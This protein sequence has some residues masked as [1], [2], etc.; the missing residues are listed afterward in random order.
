MAEPAPAPAAPSAPP[1]DA[2]AEPQHQETQPQEQPAAATPSTPDAAPTPT[3]APAPASSP[4]PAAAPAPAPHAPPVVKKFT[5]MNATRKFLEKTSASTANTIP[6]SGAAAQ[7]AAASKTPA[8]RPTVTPSPSASKLVAA[9]LSTLNSSSAPAGWARPPAPPAATTP[10]DSPTPAAAQPLQQL[11]RPASGSKTR[12]SSPGKPVWGS[13]AAPARAPAA[14]PPTSDFPTAAEAATRAQRERA[15]PRAGAPAANA[16][17][18]PSAEQIRS[19]AQKQ[20]MAETAAVFRGAHLDPNASHWDEMDDDEGF[21]DAVVEFGDGTQYKVEA[22]VEHSPPRPG[23]DQ[24][25]RAG[26]HANGAPPGQQDDERGW[27]RVTAKGGA[28][29]SSTSSA[30]TASLATPSPLVSPHEPPS[31]ALY[32]DRSGRFEPYNGKPSGARGGPFRRD[33]R[34]SAHEP[35]PHLAQRSPIQLLQK[36][37]PGEHRT[38]PQEAARPGVGPAR[39]SGSV[40]TLPSVFDRPHERGRPGA[41]EGGPPSRPGSGFHAQSQRGSMGPPPPPSQLGREAPPHLGRGPPSTISNGRESPIS[42]TSS[43]FS[44]RDSVSSAVPPAPLSIGKMASPEVPA[45]PVAAPAVPVPT[46][47]EQEELMKQYRLELAEKARKRRQEEEE[48]RNREKE[49]ARKKAA[50][51]EERMEAEKRAKEEA[52]AAKAEAE[53]KERERQEAERKEAAAK[54]EAERQAEAERKAAAAAAARAAAPPFERP[55]LDTAASSSRPL[56]F[57]RP[58]APSERGFGFQPAPPVRAP[59]IK[60]PPTPDPVMQLDSWRSKAAPPPSPR[61]TTPV[62]KPTQSFV[63]SLFTTDF[64]LKPDEEVE[65]IDFSDISKLAPEPSPSAPVPPPAPKPPPQIQLLQRPPGTF[66]KPGAPPPPGPPLKSDTN[67]WRKP[68]A[69]TA[70]TSA[71]SPPAAPPASGG[72]APWARRPADGDAQAKPSLSP[73]ASTSPT[74]SPPRKHGRTTSGSEPLSPRSVPYREAP[75]SALTDTMSRI[76]GAL[77]GMQTEKE[78]SPPS[79]RPTEAPPAQAK[80]KPNTTGSVW[81]EREANATAKRIASQGVSGDTNERLMQLSLVFLPE[82]G[83]PT[84]RVRLPAAEAEPREAVSKKQL[85]LWQTITHVRFD[86]LSLDPPPKGMS[87]RTLMV[88]ESLFDRLHNRKGAPQYTV[89]LPK[90]RL[91]NSRALARIEAAPIASTSSA[92]APRLPHVPAPVRQGSN[93]APQP[94][95]GSLF[96]TRSKGVDEPSWRKPAAPKPEQEPQSEL[97]P[98]SRSPPPDMDRPSVAQP[99]SSSVANPDAPKTPPTTLTTPWGQSPLGL[100]TINSPSS[101]PPDRDH[102]KQVWSQKLDKDGKPSGNSLRD[103][104][105]EPTRLSFS[106]QEMK[107][108]EGDT[109]P[110]TMS[111]TNS[112]TTSVTRMSV[113]DAHRAFQ[114]VPSSSSA[115]SSPRPPPRQPSQNQQQPSAPTSQPLPTHP[116]ASPHRP[117]QPMPMRIFGPYPPQGS[118]HLAPAP[119][120]SHLYALPPQP[121]PGQQQRP[122]VN[123]APPQMAQGWVVAPAGQQP[124][125]QQFMRP[126]PPGSPYMV[127]YGPP[128]PGVYLTAPP[129]GQPPHQMPKP[130]QP[131]QPGPP[132]AGRG[133]GMPMMSPGPSQAQPH[134]SPVP[135]P[136]QI[137]QHMAM[138]PYQ[139]G[140]I[141]SIYHM[142]PAPGQGMVHPHPGAPPGQPMPGMYPGGPPR[143]PIMQYPSAGGFVPAPPPQQHAPFLPRPNW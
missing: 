100:S 134:I 33:S 35:P 43:R 9:K 53:R 112:G 56:S 97:N 70:Q 93:P 60:E 89:A 81:R 141:P 137:L 72:P 7:A 123:G 17:A 130:G 106:M 69:E 99:A 26:S 8:A 122:P 41:P 50:E 48:E 90:K 80:F 116:S 44:R 64:S 15:P 10:G 78:A 104:A 28:A 66:S 23:P 91:V 14:A 117:P 139:G 61:A 111:S 63:T 49:R 27:T 24:A 65:I 92:P 47:E 103:I 77:D 11:Q 32:N 110:P 20:A 129:Q 136:G 67:V 108:D 6:T 12:S 82:P 13:P 142:P 19:D 3:P 98:V 62:P 95:R 96:G 4:A 71:G 73:V 68:T 128:P 57:G 140:P 54:A 131:L 42:A 21:L 114:T 138:P 85:H 55:R 31:R 30:T 120:G 119:H 84:N 22:P 59:S 101:K 36:H 127:A 18:E 109:P 143:P 1:Q 121:Q 102:L 88:E 79:I 40:R 115:T 135:A 126:P 133:R 16:N 118:P 124:Q 58:R 37:G 105:D 39:D 107:S 132:G 52:A 113:Q 5:P 51:L 75:M 46:P 87:R 74:I 45:P 125:Q 94:G 83:S 34:D 25:A 38:P 29:P 2:P 86:I 76:K